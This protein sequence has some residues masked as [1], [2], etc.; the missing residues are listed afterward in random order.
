MFEH[1]PDIEV[2]YADLQSLIKPDGLMLFYTLLS[3][4]E[5]AG[6]AAALVVP[7]PR[8]GHISLFSA[9]ACASA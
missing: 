7:A 9:R 3:D 4:E 6:P 2:L 5:V 1:V 8:N